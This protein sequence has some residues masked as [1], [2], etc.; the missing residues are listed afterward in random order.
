MT[1]QEMHYDFKMKL[2]KIDSEQYR[3]LRIPEIDWKLNEAIEMFVKQTAE[4]HQVP[5]YGIETTQ[6]N[7]DAIRTLVVENK[8]LTGSSKEYDSYVFGLPDDYMFFVSVK[9]V[10]SK[11]NCTGKTCQVHIRQHDDDFEKSVFDKSSFEWG[12]VNGTF[13][14]KGLRIHTDGSFVVDR[15]LLNYIKKHPYVH[16]AQDFLPARQYRNLNGVL[17]NGRQDCVLPDQTHREIVDMAVYI[18]SVDLDNPNLQLK[19]AK[20]EQNKV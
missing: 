15:L 7:I 5:F 9:A 17:L 1:I 11:G 10:I 20:I 12:D 6:R 14:G 4:P 19:Q 2:N 3:N 8:L 16:N 13:D 18:T